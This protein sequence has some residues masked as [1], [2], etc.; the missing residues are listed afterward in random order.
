MTKPRAL[1]PGDTL[2][3]VSP[4]SPIAKEKL[5]RGLEVLHQAGYRTKVYPHA[6]DANDY[7]AGED[8]DRMSDLQQAFADPEVDAVYCSR[9]GYGCARLM[10]YL[11][12]DAMA[13]SG[14]MFLGFSDITTIHLALNRRGL[15]T[16]YSPM[17]LSFSV[18]RQ[19]W[20]Y[21]SF[22]GALKGDTTTPKDAP[23]ANTL[24]GG[25]VE[26]EVCG[27]CLCLLT[28]S[29][30]TPDAL[31]AAGKILLIEDI[32]EHPHRVDAMFTHLITS[33]IL[34]S[35]A[36]IVVGEMTGTDEKVD[37]SIGGRPWRD[38]VIDRVLPLGIPAVIDFPFGHVKNML[39]MP[40]GIRARLD[41]DAGT[42]TYLE[43]CAL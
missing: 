39:T 15:V 35:A 29:L 16:L 18:E 11:D 22:L 32:D 28:D 30:G 40:L 12:L 8:K 33:G 26:A 17:A 34:Q 14:K 9:G 4:S 5:E 21:E 23:K 36:G 1:Q 7:M 38:I 31:D 19:P 24:V 42:L 37:A 43:R 27:G 25:T 6:L 13:A 10:P 3:I 20:V 41:A 2:A